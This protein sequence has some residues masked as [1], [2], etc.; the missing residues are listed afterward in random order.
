MK[1]PESAGGGAPVVLLVGSDEGLF[2]EVRCSLEAESP[3]ESTAEPF[4]VETAPN[5]DSLMQ[6]LRERPVAA[7]LLAR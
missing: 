7:V 5:F 1:T 6:R 2:G 3:G 4:L